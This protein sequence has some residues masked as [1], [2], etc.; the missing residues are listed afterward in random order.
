MLNMNK[1][2][3]TKLLLTKNIL[4]QI[5]ATAFRMTWQNTKKLFDRP[6]GEYPHKKVHINLLPSLE[7]AHHRAYL[8]PC[9]HEQTFKK[10]LQ[11]LVHIGILEE[12]DASGWALPYFILP[13]RMDMSE[14]SLIYGSLTNASYAKNI[15][16]LLCMI[17]CTIFQDTSIL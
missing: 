5:N 10:E 7:P 4:H 12:F 8:V 13:K 3:S 15:H 1:S 11:H 9:I 2:I 16:C 17:S 14:K 6:L